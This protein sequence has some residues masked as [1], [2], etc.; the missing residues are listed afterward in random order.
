[1]AEF[2]EDDSVVKGA[3]LMELQSWEFLKQPEREAAWKK[4]QVGPLATRHL[5]SDL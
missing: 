3:A 5:Y 4:L 1:M 2:F